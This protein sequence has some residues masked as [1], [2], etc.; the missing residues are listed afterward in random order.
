MRIQVLGPLAA[1]DARGALEL[2][3]PKQRAVVALLTIA[4]GH[5]VSVDKLADDLWH[6]EPPR[7]A[8][9]ALQAYVSNLRRIL[10]P[11]RPPRSPAT[12][13][14]SQAPG[15]ALRLGVDDVDA[16]RF[17]AALRAPD[18]DD[19][20][21]RRR[22]LDAAL[23]LW[24]GS[25]FADFA[26]APWARAESA[27]L[28]ELRSV[29]RERQAAATLEC[30]DAAT[31]ALLAD[32]LRRDHPLREDAWRIMAHALYLSGRQA[33][34]LGVIREA[35][36][37]LSD[38]LGLDPGPALVALES[39]VLAQR[40]PVEATAVRPAVAVT[41]TADDP[42]R[43]RPG[44][45]ILGRDTEI[46]AVRT[47]A[48]DTGADRRPGLCLVTGSAGDG[49]TALLTQI[50]DDLAAAGWQVAF[51]RCP[52]ADGAPPAWAWSQ[53]L[54]ALCADG[55]A[56]D[57]LATLLARA[58]DA[59]PN[60]ETS[61]EMSRFLLHRKV[62]DFL[63]ERAAD[64]PVAVFLDDVH[65]AESETLSL[66]TEVAGEA[67]VLLVVAYRRDEVGRHL[68]SAL[69]SLAASAP[70]RIDL[71]GLALADA[72]Q[73]VEAEAASTPKPEVMQVLLERTGGNPFYL[74]ESA[75]LL[76][77]EGA[78]V[79]VSAVPAGV[80]DVLRRRLSRLP[81]I[82]V[83]VLRLA[84]LVGRHADLDV[85]LHAAEVDEDTVLDG[86]DAGVLAGL[87]DVGD[88]TMSFT[89]ALVRDT[90]VDDIPRF[91]R[92]RWHRR[93]AAAVERVHPND[94]AALAYHHGAALTIDNARIAADYAVAAADLADSNF[95]YD[96]AADNLRAADR[97]LT[98][99]AGVDVAERVDLLARLSR[100][101]LADGL[102]ES[103]RETRL[104]AVRLAQTS[105]RPELV[106]PAVTAWSLPTPLITRRYGFVDADIV[107]AVEECLADER[108]EAV[109][110]RCRLLAVLVDEVYGEHEERAVSAAREVADLS[111]HSC[112]PNVRGL[113]INAYL[114]LPHH[115]T[116][117]AERAAMA[118]ELI[119]LGYDSGQ[120]VFA[121]IGHF[122]HVQLH[123]ARGELDSATIHLAEMDDLVRKFRWG[124]ARASNLLIHGMLAHARGDFAASMQRYRE[125][126]AV[127]EQQALADGA[128]MTALAMF[129]VGLSTGD[130]AQY[131]ST[132]TSID[133][134]ARDVLKD[135]I[136]LALLE[137]GRADEARAQRRGVRPVRKDFFHSLLLTTRGIAVAAL[138][139]RREAAGLFDD[140]LRYSGQIGGANTGC[141]A[142]GPVDTV[143]G[144]LCSLLGD[145][146]RAA[147]F[148]ASAVELALRCGNEAWANTARSRLQVVH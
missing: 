108:G 100:A 89:H 126:Y 138:G 2:G 34:S 39:D 95:A 30:G 52:E 88:T 28:E 59:A 103:S 7:R 114:M 61:A 47:V 43:G 16:W 18:A 29:A 90:L 55:V 111:A 58:D 56:D 36:A 113:G 118:D 107:A 145:R 19:P 15:Y 127:F 79:A 10:E 73:L 51:G 85:L 110:D 106:V 77:S 17:E 32:A 92:L 142:V 22:R 4:H 12:L 9:G 130:V 105:N 63:R 82:A 81:D 62:V 99:I 31:A 41:L 128:G 74:K 129:S 60:A 26:D 23:G 140:L 102:T 147:T 121:L 134:S 38:E 25:A 48:D 75:R 45:R 24:Q 144:D 11:D 115:L 37:M 71:A 35:R 1:A 78:L 20:H 93:I 125:A 116:P 6:G 13:L 84:A 69:A 122:G 137:A 54:R 21:E 131:V 148:Y 120:E 136:A 96:V 124:Q 8:L 46:D 109:D 76:R 33:E 141:Y 143:L 98:R 104:R 94:V 139:E 50:A 68:E 91:R 87:L 72:T 80:R 42:A 86:L 65:R 53:A 133:S 97:A 5:V 132:L 44:T 112:D 27:R 117:D 64:A 14:V 123:G 49:K 135:P 40:V 119:T 70:L 67:P 83:S 66:L 101:L 57:A 3:G 146:R